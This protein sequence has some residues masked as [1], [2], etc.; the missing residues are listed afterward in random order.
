MYGK[1]IDLFLL[2]K[3]SFHQPGQDA[4]IVADVA[5]G[6]VESFLNSTTFKKII[7]KQHCVAETPEQPCFQDLKVNLKV[8]CQVYQ[9]LT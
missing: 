5:V 1:E 9:S 7:S 4:H 3:A 8:D 2:F 6:L